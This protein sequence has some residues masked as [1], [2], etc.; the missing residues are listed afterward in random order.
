MATWTAR[1]DSI[2]IKAASRLPCTQANPRRHQSPR[3]QECSL[4]ARRAPHPCPRASHPKHSQTDREYSTYICSRPLTECCHFVLHVL[5]HIR[6]RITVVCAE[7]SIALLQ[8]Y[9]S[10][11]AYWAAV[12]GSIRPSLPPTSTSQPFMCVHWGDMLVCVTYSG[13]SLDVGGGAYITLTFG[14]NIRLPNFIQH[15]LGCR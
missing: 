13:T 1:Q 3:S 2:A 14:V 7:V 12:S 6:S 10:R 15:M 4:R 5:S 8:I 9:I 11:V